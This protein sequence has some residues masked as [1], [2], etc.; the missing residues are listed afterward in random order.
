M[1]ESEFK[2][3]KSKKWEIDFPRLLAAV[4]VWIILLLVFFGKVKFE[5]VI[6]IIGRL[7]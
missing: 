5:D 3:D 2:N 7:L 4:T 1:S 6:E